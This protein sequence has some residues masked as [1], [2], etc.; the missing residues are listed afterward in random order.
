VELLALPGWQT[1]A[2]SLDAWVA[3]LTA[4]AGPIVVTRESATV[5]W[6]EAARH[7]LRGY[8]MLAGQSV[9]AINFELSGSDPAP[10]THA[11]TAAADALGW[12]LH[13]DDGEDEDDDDEPT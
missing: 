12:E 10:G 7:R 3:Q 4:H 2:T 6:L 13:P 1:A 8:V 11:L 5:S 9:E